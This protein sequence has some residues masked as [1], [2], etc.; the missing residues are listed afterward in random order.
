M[1]EKEGINNRFLGAA[2]RRA[3]GGIFV[4]LGFFFEGFWMTVG[5]FLDDFGAVPGCPGLFWALLGFLV[6]LG[7]SELSGGDGGGLF[8]CTLFVL[9]LRCSLRGA[10][11]RV[12]K[13]GQ[14]R[15]TN[16]IFP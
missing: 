12:P 9:F 16:V 10:F 3:L 15:T 1:N 2:Q 11:K 8:F 7:Y 13:R 4:T 14:T 6:I 5:I